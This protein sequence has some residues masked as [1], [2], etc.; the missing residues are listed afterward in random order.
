MSSWSCYSHYPMKV[1]FMASGF[2]GGGGGADAGTAVGT[3]GIGS[4][5]YVALVWWPI[6]AWFGSGCGAYM[7]TIAAAA[8]WFVFAFVFVLVFVLL[9]WITMVGPALFARGLVLAEEEL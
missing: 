4:W 5:R 6:A 9:F 1:H 8:V 3:W 7:G 2:M